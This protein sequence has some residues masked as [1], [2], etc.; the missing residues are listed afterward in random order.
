MS[1]VRSK[2]VVASCLAWLLGSST[3]VASGLYGGIGGL[4]TNF[5]DAQDDSQVGLRVYGGYDFFQVS[6]AFRV[7]IEAGYTRT[8]SFDTVDSAN[9]TARQ[10]NGDVGLQATFT[11]LR[12]LAFHARVGHEWGDSEGTIFALGGSIKAFPLTRIRA[13]YQFRNDYDAAMLSI[14]V[15]LP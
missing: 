7:G 2:L 14:E 1:K 10:D 11:A 6:A 15:R 13:D 12:P 3:A 5:E 9:G 4:H 8:G